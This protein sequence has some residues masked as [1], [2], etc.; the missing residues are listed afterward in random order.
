MHYRSVGGAR[1]IPQCKAGQTEA[2]T[3]SGPRLAPI[4]A[5]AEPAEAEHVLVE[6]LAANERG[7]RF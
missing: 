7:G 1:T 6:Y 5:K 2:G 3:L 4:S